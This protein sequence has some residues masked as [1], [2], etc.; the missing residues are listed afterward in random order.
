MK[1]APKPSA[2]RRLPF[3]TLFFPVVIDPH[4]IVG[5][6]KEKMDSIISPVSSN[7]CSSTCYFKVN[8]RRFIVSAF[9]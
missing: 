9:D 3:S 7:A 5:E 8:L 1:M 6:M 4:S 2:T